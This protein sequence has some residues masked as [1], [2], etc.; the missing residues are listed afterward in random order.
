MRNGGFLRGLVAQGLRLYLGCEVREV[1]DSQHPQ[2]EE[3][4]P[5]SHTTIGWGVMMWER[6]R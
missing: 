4:F 3:N 5:A 2:E 6:D 1:M